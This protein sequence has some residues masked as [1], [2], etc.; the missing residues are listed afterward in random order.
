MV[1]GGSSINIEMDDGGYEMDVKFC[2]VECHSLRIVSSFNVLYVYG[3]YLKFCDV[4]SS[5]FGFEQK[6]FTNQEEKGWKIKG[7]SMSNR[8]KGKKG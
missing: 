6:R 3:Q 8:E 5:R 7:V 4:V 1:G 2:D